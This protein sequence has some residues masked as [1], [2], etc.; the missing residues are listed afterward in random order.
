LRERSSV[1]GCASWPIGAGASLRFL[2]FVVSIIIGGCFNYADV[3]QRVAVAAILSFNPQSSATAVNNCWNGQASSNE[4]SPSPAPNGATSQNATSAFARNPSIEVTD[5]AL[6][7]FAVA[8]ERP[9]YPR[10]IRAI[11]ISKTV[12]Q[13]HTR[14]RWAMNT[15]NAVLFL[16]LA[17]FVSGLIWALHSLA[18]TRSLSSFV[19]LCVVTFA[20]MASAAYTVDRLQGRSQQ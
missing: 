11:A 9:L 2:P 13:L 20:I 8:R 12:Y 10:Q 17:A 3:R 7:A 15:W 18:N 4:N 1:A 5:A 16:L 6:M 14:H 19:I